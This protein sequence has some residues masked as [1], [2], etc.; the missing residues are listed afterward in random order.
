METTKWPVYQ[1]VN[2]LW[3]YMERYAYDIGPEEVKRRFDDCLDK[4]AELE[5][6]QAKRSV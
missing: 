5:N 1:L 4:I 6:E 3:E 2:K